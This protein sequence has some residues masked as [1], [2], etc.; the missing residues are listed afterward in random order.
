MAHPSL[1]RARKTQRSGERGSAEGKSARRGDIDGRER[2]I[3]LGDIE[4]PHDLEGRRRNLGRYAG[5][6][7]SADDA[8]NFNATTV[9]GVIRRGD[10]NQHHQHCQAGSEDEPSTIGRRHET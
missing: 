8:V 5:E 3:R 10:A 4:R 7:R 6:M 9:I 2:V 1:A